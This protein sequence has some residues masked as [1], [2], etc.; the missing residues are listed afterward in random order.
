M[1]RSVQRGVFDPLQD[2]TCLIFQSVFGFCTCVRVADTFYT[3]ARQA[4]TEYWE[5]RDGHGL[6]IGVGTGWVI[7][8]RINRVREKA[9]TMSLDV[10][11]PFF[12]LRLKSQC[13]NANAGINLAYVTTASQ[14]PA[15]NL[16]M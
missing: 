5:L 14:A 7:L 4:L 9:K 12:F 2:S 16:A 10:A 3:S 1:Q 13:L 15:S 8:F 6:K 11:F